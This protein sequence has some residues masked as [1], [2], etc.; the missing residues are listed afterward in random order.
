MPCGTLVSVS[1]L[2]F[3][4]T[5]LLPALAELS[6]SL[7]LKSRVH[8]TDPQPQGASPLVWP[9]SRSLA[10]TQEITFVFFSYG[11]LDVSVPRVPF[12]TLWI[13]VTMTGC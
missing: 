5:G 10:A 9:L 3:S 12:V 6:N 1:R 8:V 4:R 13:H 2:T 7:L 11:Y